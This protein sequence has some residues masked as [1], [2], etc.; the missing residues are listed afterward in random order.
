MKGSTQR[1]ALVLVAALLALWP[2]HM[3]AQAGAPEV[4][5]G[6]L[7]VTNTAT[8]EVAVFDAATGQ[9]LATVP[10]GSTPVGIVAT[11]EKVYVAEEGDNRIAIIA[12]STMSV[13]NRLATAARPHHMTQSA[14]GRFIYV[15]PLRDEPSGRYRYRDRFAGRVRDW[16]G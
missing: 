8:N 14:D 13:V 6:V 7:W 16:R 2:S 11:A 3:G 9:V 4:D 10:V 5:A 15:G 1:F 12:K